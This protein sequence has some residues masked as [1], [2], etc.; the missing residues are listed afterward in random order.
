MLTLADGSLRVVAGKKSS[1][2]DYIK[3]RCQAVIGMTVE[4]ALQQTFPN[5]QAR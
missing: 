1:A 2:K 5:A 3:R 4:Q